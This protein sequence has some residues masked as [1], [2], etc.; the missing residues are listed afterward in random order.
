MM[1]KLNHN[2]NV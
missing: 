1:K 2:T